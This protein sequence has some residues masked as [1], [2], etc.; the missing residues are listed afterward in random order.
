MIIKPLSEEVAVGDASIAAARLVR[1]VNTGATEKIT[2]GNSTAA[3]LTLIANTSVVIEKEVGAAV[4]A[5]AAV[6]ATPV[7]FTN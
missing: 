6:L 2:I 3:S 1:L 7:A 4:V 5:T